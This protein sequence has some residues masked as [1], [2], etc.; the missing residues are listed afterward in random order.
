MVPFDPSD[1]I[2]R[3]LDLLAMAEREGEQRDERADQAQ[4]RHPPDVPDQRKADDDGKERGDESD[5][6]VLRHLDRPVIG[7]RNRL[8]T[9]RTYAMLPGPIG[10]AFADIRQ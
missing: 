4:S 10:I 3:Y 1:R 8:T 2:G 6:A 9:S 5:R 7:N